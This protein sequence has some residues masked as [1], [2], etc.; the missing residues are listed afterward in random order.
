MKRERP[1][2]PNPGPLLHRERGG[3]A[4]ETARL[5]LRSFTPADVDDLL[6]MDGDARVM[7]YIGAEGRARSRD[8]VVEAIGRI[9][10][11]AE[12]HPGMSLLHA[13]ERITGRFVG[14]CGLFPVPDGSA[15]ELAYR[16]PHACWGHGYA[17]E[18]ARAV[19][20]HGFR[21]LGLTRVVGLTYPQNVPSQRVLLKLGMRDEGEAEHYGRTMRVFAVER[22]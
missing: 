18:M 16:L 20:A 15:I 19:L 2:V 5:L 12:R 14:G 3:M 10:D 9:A 21:T 11:F 8:E 13:S 4:I 22:T 7:R 6:A 17:T 1:T